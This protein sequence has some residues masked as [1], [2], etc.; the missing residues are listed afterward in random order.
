MPTMNIKTLVV[1]CITLLNLANAMPAPEDQYSS[2]PSV[3]G[4]YPCDSS[5]SS[6]SDCPG[7][8]GPP[9]AS[10]DLSDSSDSPESAYAATNPAVKVKKVYKT[11]YN[12]KLAD[13]SVMLYK[14]KYYA[15]ATGH[16]VNGKRE[17]VPTAKSNKMITGWGP[18]PNALPNVG[19][20][21]YE[22][23]GSGNGLE[24]PDV[25]E[26]VSLLPLHSTLLIR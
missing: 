17:N 20:W 3:P 10:S 11:D 24:N 18:G 9:L 5:S 15:Y 19:K 23:T 25:S 7:N 14:G 26:I 21:A 1:L 12:N 2:S 16:E 4:S 22:P 13:L 6:G 8:G